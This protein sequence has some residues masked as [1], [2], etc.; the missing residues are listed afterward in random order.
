MVFC[1]DSILPWTD[2][3]V[4]NRNYL[5]TVLRLSS[6]YILSKKIIFD[7]K[8]PVICLE[9]GVIE[10]VQEILMECVLN[11]RLTATCFGGKRELFGFLNSVLS[12]QTTKLDELNWLIQ[13]YVYDDSHTVF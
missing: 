3:I 10:D 9:C 12:I 2:N 5:K 8:G 4:L 7:E 11:E 1:I 13:V 6:K